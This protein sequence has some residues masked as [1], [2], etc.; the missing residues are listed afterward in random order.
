MEG[1]DGSSDVVT[2]REH[3]HLLAL[4]DSAAPRIRVLPMEGHSLLLEG[5]LALY[6]WL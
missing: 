5:Q 4:V 6:T 1:W 2:E 3:L